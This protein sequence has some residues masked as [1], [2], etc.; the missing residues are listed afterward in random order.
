MLIAKL[1]GVDG[2]EFRMAATTSLGDIVEQRRGVKQPRFLRFAD[3]LAAERIFMREIGVRETA[4]IAQYLQDMLV[5]RVDVE[6]IVLHLPNDGA[7]FGQVASENIE[8]VHA[9]EFMQHATRLFE[10]LR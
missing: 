7:K 1:L 6:Q 4:Q 5:R 3:Q 10:E 2:A 9:L 8:L